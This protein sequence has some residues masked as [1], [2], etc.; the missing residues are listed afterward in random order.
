[1]PKRR[2]QFD[3]GEKLGGCLWTD[4][5]VSWSLGKSSS[6]SGNNGPKNATSGAN[7]WLICA[8]IG[9]LLSKRS[10]SGSRTQRITSLLLTKA[11]GF[12]ENGQ[13]LPTFAHKV[14]CAQC[15][16][17]EFSSRFLLSARIASQV[18]TFSPWS[19]TL[20]TWS[21]K[22]DY[23]ACFSVQAADCGAGFEAVDSGRPAPWLGLATFSTLF[24]VICTFVWFLTPART[25]FA[26]PARV[27]RSNSGK[28][29]SE[30][31]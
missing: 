30:S 13:N 14:N 9:S 11:I 10:T 3:E 24:W 17:K 2:V 18:P 5:R 6:I 25:S 20:G 1:M 16:A 4:W 23:P 21:Q 15:S 22:I 26:T 27:F 19:L 12:C 7:C 29:R 8:A 28:P 31:G